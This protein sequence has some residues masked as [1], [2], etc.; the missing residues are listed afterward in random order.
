MCLFMLEV[1]SAYLSIPA[2]I[3]VFEHK[4]TYIV[5][6]SLHCVVS[7]QTSNI[8]LYT[9]S[10]CLPNQW[11][12]HEISL[13]NTK[14]YVQISVDS[15]CMYV[16]AYVCMYVCT[17]CAIDK[18]LV[19]IHKAHALCCELKI[20]LSNTKSVF[21]PQCQWFV[22]LEEIYSV[23]VSIHCVCKYTLCM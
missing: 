23:Y 22:Y 15:L 1:I 4:I 20:S 5:C 14:T 7:I 16:C 11:F 19:C 10:P 18:A 9:S 3:S 21:W 12:E 17:I 8:S 13:S 2:A 6:V